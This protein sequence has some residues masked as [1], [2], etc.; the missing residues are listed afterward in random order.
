MTHADKLILIVEGLNL[1]LGRSQILKRIT[2]SIG[3]E[4]GVI[5]LF[6]PNGAGKTSLMRCMAGLINSY[7]GALR[8]PEGRSIAFQPDGPILPKFATLTDCLDLYGTLFGDFDPHAAR[9]MLAELG[10]PLDMTVAECS[11]GMSEQLH[12]ALLLARRSRLY[13]LDEPLASVDPLTRDVLADMI[14]TRRAAGSTVLISTHLL[15]DAADLFD[16][17]IVMHQGSIV[18]TGRVDE[19]T[20]NNSNSLEEVFKNAIRHIPLAV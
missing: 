17:V 14:R 16:E 13:V 7:D 5:G 15:S 18:L 6:G 11:K 1:K 10:L 4:Q 3:A 20:H 19:L 9:Q 2:L 8:W 12:I